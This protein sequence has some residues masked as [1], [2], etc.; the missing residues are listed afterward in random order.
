MNPRALAVVAG[1]LYLITHV[2]SVVALGL[3]EPVVGAADYIVG[4]GS[5]EN[6]V[7]LGA[8]L[9]V[10][11][12][13]AIVGTSVALYP[14]VRRKAPSSALGY[15]G[16]RTLEAGMVVVGAVSLLTVVTMRQEASGVEATSLISAGEALVGI[17]DWTHLVGPNLV[18]ATSTAV[19]ALVMFR[20]G[21]VARWI[22]MLGLIGAPIIF[23]RAI[24]SAFGLYEQVSTWGAIAAL[25]VFAWEVSLAL[26]LLFKGFDEAV[27]AG[28][29]RG[30]HIEQEAGVADT[31]AE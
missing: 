24:G 3:Y 27:L 25:P 2:T 21:L 1:V 9:D 26:W 6:R 8:L 23:V 17:Y 18:L 4:T 29:G 15:V 14:V 31:G 22:G 12:A 28:S 20:T 16:L 10:V 7:V 19:L 5:S 13:M 30:S 11:L